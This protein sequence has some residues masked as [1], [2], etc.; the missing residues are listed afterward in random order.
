[1]L[2]EL[3]SSGSGLLALLSVVSACGV[4]AEATAVLKALRVEPEGIVLASRGAAQRFIL[5]AVY[6]DGTETDA[7]RTARVTSLNPEV[8]SVDTACRQFLA[9]SSGR[10]TIRVAQGKV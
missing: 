9:K 3:R 8:V 10:A 7:N 2:A 6:S 5:T 4:E 1:M